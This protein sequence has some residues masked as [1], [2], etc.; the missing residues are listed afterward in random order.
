MDN[1]ERYA[2][3][4]RKR[5]L[6]TTTTVGSGALDSVIVRTASIPGCDGSS[7]CSTHVRLVA[8][9]GEVAAIGIERR[10]D[11]IVDAGLDGVGIGFVAEA[12]GV[13]EGHVGIDEERPEGQNCKEC[14]EHVEKNVWISGLLKCF[15]VLCRG[16]IYSLM[17][18]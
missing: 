18:M 14:A 9:A 4:V 13:E 1:R 6:A 17:E 10:S 7:S 16:V 8:F 12:D 15:G 2:F 3:V 5:D 11:R